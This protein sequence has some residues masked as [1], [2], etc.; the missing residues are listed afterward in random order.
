MI[1]VI[2]ITVILTLCTTSAV[3]MAYYSL[4]KT[5]GGGTTTSYDPTT[6]N[7]IRT[8]GESLNLFANYRIVRDI[9]KDL[10]AYQQN[11]AY[12]NKV[13]LEII[14]GKAGVKIEQG[15]YVDIMTDTHAY[16]IDFAS[17]N[18]EGLGQA[19]VYAHYT[20]LKPGLIILIRDKKE[21][22]TFN[23]IKPALDYYAELFDMDFRVFNIIN[24]TTGEF[25]EH[26]E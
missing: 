5:R 7:G 3:G 1:K 26:G 10:R 9:S 15:L 25:T 4:N 12:Y 19:L 24:R 21:L 14:G 20:G 23:K 16:E 22:T 17:K 2:L 8:Y 13:L 6:G 18:Y 11:E